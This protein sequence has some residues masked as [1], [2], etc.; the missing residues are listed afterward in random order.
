MI[1]NRIAL[2]IEQHLIKDQT[3]F[4]AGKSCTRQLLNL[5]QHIED[6]YQECKISGTAFVDISAAYDTVNHDRLLIQKLYITQ[7]SALCRLIQNL[8]SNRRFYVEL[9]NE[10]SRWRLPHL[11]SHLNLESHINS[12]CRS[13]YFHLRNIRSIR[14]ML[15]DNACSQLIHA[16]VTVRI[17]YCNSLLYGLLDCSLIN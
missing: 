13:D 3:G 4:R 12:V 1:L 9:N 10:R 8:L 5:T 15:M 7:D 2:T 14:N 17:D 6:G 16:L 11:C